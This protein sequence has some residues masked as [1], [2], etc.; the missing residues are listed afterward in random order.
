[1]REPGQDDAATGGLL[2]G[3]VEERR[4]DGERPPGVQ[5]AVVDGAQQ[6]APHRSFVRPPVGKP[7]KRIGRRAD[8]LP[9]IGA[10]PAGIMRAQSRQRRAVMMGKPGVI[11]R[12]H[13]RFVDRE[14]AEM[15][16]HQRAVVGAPAALGVAAEPPVRQVPVG[17][18]VA[19]VPQPQHL[20]DETGREVDPALVGEQVAGD[21]GAALRQQPI[22]P[23]ARQTLTVIIVAQGDKAAIPHAGFHNGEVARLTLGRQRR[24]DVRRQHQ[25][26]AR[27][28]FE[29]LGHWCQQQDIGI[30]ID[31]L[32]ETLAKQVQKRI[33]LDRRVELQNVVPPF[34]V[35][36]GRRP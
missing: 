23:P 32:A 25:T 33:R 28:P 7:G 26:V 11:A 8:A 21:I 12:Q 13:V 34:H 17:R 6:P 19:G 29:H 15:K 9:A 22:R 36:N 18:V 3:L 24:G 20:G 10:D 1:M 4:A 35:R 27:Q 5:P 14:A 16:K 30:E 31:R 2:I